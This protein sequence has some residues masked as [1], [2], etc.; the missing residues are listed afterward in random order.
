M[1][2]DTINSIK[3]A[4]REL[5]LY[6][7]FKTK[8]FKVKDECY[9]KEGEFDLV[10][11]DTVCAKIVI[12]GNGKPWEAEFSARADY[13]RPFK[14]ELGRLVFND[15]NPIVCRGDN[16]SKGMVS[17]ETLLTWANQVLPFAD[18]IQRKNKVV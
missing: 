11:R 2:D 14:Y 4:G 8:P 3:Y 13:D 16:W 17:D 10:E 1:R 18:G 12:L 7:E 5:T 6:I 9:H 15:W